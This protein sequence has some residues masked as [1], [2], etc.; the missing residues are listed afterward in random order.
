MRGN[1]GGIGDSQSLTIVVVALLTGVFRHQAVVK[2]VVPKS[3]LE[4]ICY[5]KRYK[6]NL[7][8]VCSQSHGKQDILVLVSF[9][10]T[11]LSQYHLIFHVFIF[12]QFLNRRNISKSKPKSGAI[13]GV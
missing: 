2:W 9:R 3:V 6:C 1:V 7:S 8:S 12:S 4:Q 10:L 11:F 13:R 5:Y